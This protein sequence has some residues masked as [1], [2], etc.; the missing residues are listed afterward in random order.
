MLFDDGTMLREISNIVP[1]M[2]WRRKFIWLLWKPYLGLHTTKIT[3]TSY[4]KGVM[5]Q[6][7]FGGKPKINSLP[8]WWD[9]EILVQSQRNVI[10]LLF[11][12]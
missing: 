11:G 1:S 7:N 3:S 12:L 2:E 10:N 6:R 4:G 9:R 5:E 8:L